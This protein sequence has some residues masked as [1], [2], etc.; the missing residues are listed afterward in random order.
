MRR[1]CKGFHRNG[2]PETR[3]GGY[4][5]ASPAAGQGV[6][7]AGGWPLL[8]PCPLPEALCKPKAGKQDGQRGPCSTPLCF[9]LLCSV[10]SSCASMSPQAHQRDNPPPAGKWSSLPSP[11]PIIQAVCRGMAP[12]SLALTPAVQSAGLP[13]SE[14]K[15]RSQGKDSL[16]TALRPWLPLSL[17]ASPCCFLRGGGILL[18]VLAGRTGIAVLGQF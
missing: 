11:P 13:L 10:G 9:A 5:L 3:V 17:M 4:I 14:E 7:Y 15:G 16:T 6:T 12:P 18:S 1:L 2:Q 8:P